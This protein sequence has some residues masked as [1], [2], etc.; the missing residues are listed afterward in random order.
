MKCLLVSSRSDSATI[1]GLGVIGAGQTLEVSEDQQEMF[2]L[3]RG[4]PVNKARLPE[5]VETVF[6]MSS[7]KGDK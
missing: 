5:G 1:D 7:A 3:V 4:L 6:D 2:T